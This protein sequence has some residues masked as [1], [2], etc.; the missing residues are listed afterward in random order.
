VI[1]TRL[2]VSPSDP[3]RRDAVSAALFAA[4]AEGILEDGERLVVVF[5]D[6]HHARAAEAAARAADAAAATVCE[7][8]DPG[9]WTEAWRRGVRA[10]AVGRL[11][12]APPWLAHEHPGEATILVEPGFGFGTGEHESTRLT[13]RLLQQAV[14]PGDAVA[15]VGCGSAVLAMAA[16]RLGASRVIAIELDSQGVANALDNVAINALA[17]V[18]KVIEGDAEVLLPLLGPAR[19]IAANIIASV[20]VEM[21]P[22]FDASLDAGGELVVGGILV[23]ERAQFVS[24]ALT[25][26]FAVVSEAQEGDWWSARLLRRAA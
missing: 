23:A 9:D 8:Y 13:L 19:V 15:D 4:G 22:V 3:A 21:L 7:A 20:L 16:A 6:E 2:A 18:V 1:Y 24:D 11:V 17:D 14:R 26:G 5:Q 10:H 25:A 12:I